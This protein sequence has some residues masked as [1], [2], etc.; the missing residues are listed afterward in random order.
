MDHYIPKE[1]SQRRF[2]PR[3]RASMDPELS[4]TMTRSMGEP[5]QGG[6]GEDGASAVPGA[7]GGGGGGEALQSSENMY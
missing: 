3:A 1:V 2:W 6:G 4:R 5:E 7:C